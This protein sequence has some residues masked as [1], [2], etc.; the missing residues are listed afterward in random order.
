METFGGDRNNLYY[1]FD[2]CYMAICI[3]YNALNYTL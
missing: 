2:G 1:N 3:Y